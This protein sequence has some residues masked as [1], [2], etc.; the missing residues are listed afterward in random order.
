MVDFEHGMNLNAVKSKA[1]LAMVE[2]KEPDTG[3]LHKSWRTRLDAPKSS[4]D[5]HKTPKSYGLPGV[6]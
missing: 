3:H 1:V 4:R 5:E 2:I 6:F